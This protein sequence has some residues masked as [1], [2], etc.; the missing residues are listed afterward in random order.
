MNVGSVRLVGVIS[1]SRD[2]MMQSL[3]GLLVLCQA[4]NSSVTMFSG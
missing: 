3:M 4:F 2:M 1:Y